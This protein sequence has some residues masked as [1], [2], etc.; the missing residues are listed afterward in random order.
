MALRK[1]RTFSLQEHLQASNAT[2]STTRARTTVENMKLYSKLLNSQDDLL[3]RQA[4]ERAL[5]TGSWL[6]VQL[7]AV[8][9]T[10][11]SP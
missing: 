3:V 5:D 1:R 11:L 10:E 6:S 2:H 7:L 4:L 8:M 9:G